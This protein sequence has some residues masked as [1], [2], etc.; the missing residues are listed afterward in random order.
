MFV[1][2]FGWLCACVCSRVCACFVVFVLVRLCSVLVFDCVCLPVGL[3]VC[4]SVRLFVCLCICL[5][6]GFV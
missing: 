4:L 6:V 5:C 1:R 3:S 2:F